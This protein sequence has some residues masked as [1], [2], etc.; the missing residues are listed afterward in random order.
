MA[1]G[2]DPRQLLGGLGTGSFL[3]MPTAFYKL[4]GK[5]SGSP[6]KM[7][8]RVRGKHHFLKSVIARG[9]LHQL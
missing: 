8:T 2:L 5:L 1:K 3:Q 4:D 6:V 7:L 9:I